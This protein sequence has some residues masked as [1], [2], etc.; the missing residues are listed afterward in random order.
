MPVNGLF[1]ENSSFIAYNYIAFRIGGVTGTATDSYFQG[2]A[3]A[4]EVTTSGNGTPSQ[5]VVTDSVALGVR[6][7]TSGFGVAGVHSDFA[8]YLTW[9]GGSIESR[10]GV[11]F[12]ISGAVT[13]SPTTQVIGTG[14][15]IVTTFTEDTPALTVFASANFGITGTPDLNGATIQVQYLSH[16]SNLDN[17]ALLTQGLV[18]ITGSDVYYNAVLVGTVTGGTNGSDLLITLNAAATP[19]H[20]RSIAGQHRI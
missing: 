9:N 6:D 1:I 16:F 12:P 14:H 7:A 8:S 10:A 4:M 17:L 5:F 19:S 2:G 11:M 13:L 18:S 15:D 3:F 20:C